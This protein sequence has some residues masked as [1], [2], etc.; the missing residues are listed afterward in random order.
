MDNNV[1]SI[2]DL[3]FQ[4][5]EMENPYSTKNGKGYAQYTKDGKTY[6]LEATYVNGKKQGIHSREKF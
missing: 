6:I 1:I 3:T 2:D 4:S 5:V